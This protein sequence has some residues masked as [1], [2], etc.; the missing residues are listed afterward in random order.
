MAAASIEQVLAALEIPTPA[1]G[2][3]GPDWI[4]RPSGGGLTSDSPATG[5]ALGRVLRASLE[6]YDI[7]VDAARRDVACKQV[8]V[9]RPIGRRRVVG[10]AEPA[11]PDSALAVDPRAAA[12][13]PRR[14]S[15]VIGNE[16]FDSSAGTEIGPPVCPDLKNRLARRASASSAFTG[17]TSGFRP[18]GWPVW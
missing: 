8:L 12:L 6:D 13:R 3:C 7:V 17:N 10:H 11:D 16:G 4:P 18:P 2:A 9:G 15:R 5:E 14:R 1:S